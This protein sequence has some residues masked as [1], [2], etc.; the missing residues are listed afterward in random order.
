LELRRNSPLSCG[1][2]TTCP[3]ASAN[4][5]SRRRKCCLTVVWT[6]W[7]EGQIT[8]TQSEPS[9]CPIIHFAKPPP[10]V[11]VVLQRPVKGTGYM[12]SPSGWMTGFFFEQCWAHALATAMSQGGSSCAV[13][14]PCQNPTKARRE[15]W[16]RALPHCHTTAWQ[17]DAQTQKSADLKGSVYACSAHASKTLQDT[18]KPLAQL[19]ACLDPMGDVS[20]HMG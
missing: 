8:V 14:W 16:V 10:C 4:V 15:P 12:C 13:A 5:H 1:P 7:L 17:F 2:C 6:W 3:C 18:F 19:L 9:H 11:W 20:R